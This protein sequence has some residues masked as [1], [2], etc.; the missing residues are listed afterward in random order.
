VAGSGRLKRAAS[1]RKPYA[2]YFGSLCSWKGIEALV[3]ALRG[4]LEKA[5]GYRFVFVGRSLGLVQGVDPRVFM[6]DRLGSWP[7][8]ICVL[9]SMPHDELYPYVEDAEFVVFPTLADN[10]PNVVLEAMA[11][12]KCIISTSGRGVDEQLRHEHSGLLVPAGDPLALGRMMLRVAEM[13][14]AERPCYGQRAFE[15][16]QLFAPALCGDLIVDEYKKAI[17]LHGSSR[18]RV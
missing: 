1:V 12:K 15:P 10:S 2:M 11:L 13:S 16:L 9:E 17:A 14:P 18:R 5:D 6:L 4:F 3:G 7:N 8:R